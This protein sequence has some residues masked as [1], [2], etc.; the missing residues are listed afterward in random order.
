MDGQAGMIRADGEDF[1]KRALTCLC[2]KGKAGAMDCD[3]GDG[4]A[5]VCRGVTRMRDEAV[6]GE[7]H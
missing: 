4:V 5:L 1:L 2:R 3:R 6:A 7:K